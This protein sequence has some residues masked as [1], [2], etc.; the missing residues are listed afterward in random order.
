MRAAGEVG[1]AGVGQV[2]AEP[3]VYGRLADRTAGRDAVEHVVAGFGGGVRGRDVARQGRGEPAGDRDGPAL[4]VLG[5]A[6]RQRSA[7]RVRVGQGQAERFGDS[8]AGAVEHPEQDR[9]D[10]G[11]VG[12]A[13]HGLGVDRGE[14]AAHLV[15]GEYVRGLVADADLGCRGRGVGVPA[16][17][18]GVLGQLAQCQLV[19]PDGGGPQ[20]TA[21]EEPVDGFP[22]DGPVR[23]A[24]L[25]AVAGEL[26]QHP[27]LD[28][29]PVPAGVAR[30]GQLG[31]QVLQRGLRHC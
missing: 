31:D 24:L 10:H 29:E 30:G 12:V 9:V 22:G 15:V 26:A 3:H 18:A 4:A 27:F 8:Q 7:A 17:R 16:G 11:L 6:D 1:D 5:V 14:Q 21:V 25:P 13:G 19:A 23:V 28:L 20:V 2:A